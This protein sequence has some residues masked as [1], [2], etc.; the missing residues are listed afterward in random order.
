M[1]FNEI[2]AIDI[3]AGTQDILI[4]EKDK[5]IENCVKMI[6]PSYC[7]II[8]ARIKEAT[9][10]GANIFLHGGIMGGH[11]LSSS[12]KKHIKAGHKV[13][14]TA[15]AAK[16]FR[17]N[18]EEIKNWGIE[19]VPSNP[20]HC[21]ELELTDLNLDFL[22]ASLAHYGIT[23]P[24]LVAIAVQDHG[25]C[26]N[27]SNRK[28]RFSHWKKFLDNGGNLSELI[29]R[30][31]P[32]YFTRMISIKNSLKCET[33]FMDTGPAGIMG[34]FCDKKVEEYRE[35]GLVIVNIGNQHV[36]C[37]IVKGDRIFAILEHHSREM[38]EEKIVDVIKRFKER[39]ITDEEVFEGRGHGVC[40]SADLRE[41]T[42]DWPVIITGPKRQLAS[43]GDYYFA[44]PNGD[45]MLTGCFGLLEGARKI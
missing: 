8:S 20:G 9:K 37:S 45:M 22:A 12:V 23:L 27:G 38:N 35:K 30:E 21:I 32:P 6:L 16:T 24:S 19:I 33:L 17:D 43:G 10:E 14:S 40:F 28:F 36:I 4:Y 7:S 29:Y 5:Y 1:E 18:P 44:V 25:E 13:Y 2:L 15:M 41:D 42:S 11:P 34:A 39:N 3:G 31:P 26:I